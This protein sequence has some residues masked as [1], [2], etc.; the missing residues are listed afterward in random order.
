MAG[1]LLPEVVIRAVDSAGLAMSG[2][3]LYFYLTGTTTPA[4]TYTSSALSVANANPVVADSGGLFSPIY[5]DPAVTYRVQLK[6][7]GGVLISDVDPYGSAT[8]PIEAT[9]GEV[10]AGTATA[11]FISPRR[12][13]AGGVTLIGYTPLNKAG[14]TATNLLITRGAS[15]AASHAGFLG[16]PIT[17]LDS[18]SDLALSALGGMVRHTSGSAHTWTLQP[19]ATIAYPLGAAFNLRNFGSGIVTLARGAGVSLRLA[20]SSTDADKSLAQY[21]QATVV[22]ED[23][24]IWVI[25]GTG[26]T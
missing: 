2:A 15:P 20:G 18:T 26:V 19:V 11:S 7:S 25:N 12:A 16:L 23:T 22:Q 14:D 10:T 4:N 1:A 13:G 6:T 3:K 9:G 24:N 8:V 17:T 21:A 5:L